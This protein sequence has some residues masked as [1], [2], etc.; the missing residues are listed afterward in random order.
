MLV[1]LVL[2]LAAV[3]MGV[4]ARAEPLIATWLARIPFSGDTV[5]A[6]IG[7]GARAFW[8]V[9]WMLAGVGIAGALAGLPQRAMLLIATL[10]LCL[11]F[12]DLLL[13]REAIRTVIATPPASAFG[14]L[15]EAGTVQQQIARL[16]RVTLLPAGM[17]RDESAGESLALVAAVEVQLMAARANADMPA[18]PLR[19]CNTGAPAQ[20]DIDGVLVALTDSDGVDR[21]A[22]A[23]APLDCRAVLPGWLCLRGGS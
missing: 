14:S 5:M 16:G 11:Q 20:L 15:Q 1:L 4:P 3:A 9:F 13:W 7:G 12:T 21:T 18:L 19:A 22:D 17:C 8:P 6:W 23:R 2:A 10:A